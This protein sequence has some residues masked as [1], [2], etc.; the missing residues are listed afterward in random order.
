MI[1]GAL[2]TAAGLVLLAYAMVSAVGCYDPNKPPPCNPSTIDYPR[3]LDPTQPTAAR[4][5][6]VDR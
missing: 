5:A 3:C 2:L 6:G 4:D 1:R